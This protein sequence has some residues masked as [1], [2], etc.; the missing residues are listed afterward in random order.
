MT[1][2]TFL[3]LLSRTTDA[4]NQL[5][6]DLPPLYWSVYGTEIRGQVE[7][8]TDDDE[9]RQILAAWAERLDLAPVVDGLP[10]ASEYVGRREEWELAVWGVT[11]RARWA[12]D[13]RRALDACWGW[14][15]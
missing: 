3:E 10:G 9:A 5:A 7:P 6:P 11:D 12:E 8:G 14:P 4:F 15:E 1:A 13:T 2:P